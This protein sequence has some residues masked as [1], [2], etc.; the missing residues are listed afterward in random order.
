MEI[1]RKLCVLIVFTLSA[2]L[3]SGCAF[4]SE[5]NPSD[6]YIKIKPIAPLAEYEQ[7]NM[8]HNL[9]VKIENVADM[10]DSYKNRIQLYVNNYRITPDESYNFKEDYEYKMKLQPGVYKVKAK[11]YAYSGWKEEAFTI[12]TREDLKVYLDKIALLTIRLKKNHWGA[13]V[14]D[15]TYFTVQ[16]EPIN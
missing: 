14:D 3:I 16:Y 15:K 9:I 2:V 8:P 7:Q 5:I 4:R 13:P 12:N 6:S 10:N 1:N 11:Y